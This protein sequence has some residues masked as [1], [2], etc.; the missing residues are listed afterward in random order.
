MK[1]ISVLGCGWLGF[2]LA[3][4]LVELHYN[5]KGSTTSQEKLQFLE[6][7]KVNPFL[8]TFNPTFEGDEIFFNADVL[9]IN[10]PPRA[11]KLGEAFHLEQI[12]NI[13]NSK[14]LKEIKKII[15]VSSTSVYEANNNEVNENNASP[16]HFLVKAEKKLIDF[17]EQKRLNITIL[18]CGGLMGYERIPCKYFAGKT[19]VDSGHVPVN[20]VHRDDVIGVIVHILKNNIWGEIFNVVSP[21]HPTK[22]ELLEIN[23]PENNFDLPKYSET[24]SKTPY[25]IVSAQKL[26]QEAGYKFI[27]S[28]PLLFKYLK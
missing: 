8:V 14:L 10:I 6:R 9:I 28:D 23:C 2:P 20:Y 19:E 3:K 17:C 11:R 21:F 26:I 12:D 25:K 18:R 13:C 5:V 7:E 16:S 1:T 4:K 15:F 24:S 22:K 27:F